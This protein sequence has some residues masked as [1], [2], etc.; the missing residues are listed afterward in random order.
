MSGLSGVGLYRFECRHVAARNWNRQ[1]ISYT[2]D[3]VQ[4][5]EHGTEE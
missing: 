2:D 1:N 3:I 5:N 4:L